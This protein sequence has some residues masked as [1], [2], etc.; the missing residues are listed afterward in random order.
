[1][2]D[3]HLDIDNKERCGT[4]TCE[5]ALM[6]WSAVAQQSIKDYQIQ[7]SFIYVY[8]SC[9]N[10]WQDLAL[11]PPGLIYCSFGNCLFYLVCVFRKRLENLL[12]LFRLRSS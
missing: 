4:W 5:T 6:Q 10:N 11:S 7:I 2:A 3:I 9:V 12:A 1:M 8:N